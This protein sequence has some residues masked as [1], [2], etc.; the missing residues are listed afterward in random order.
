MSAFAKAE[1]YIARYGEVDDTARLT[2][3][4]EDASNY[5]LSLYIAE[6]GEDY[7]EGV[8]PIFDLNAAAVVCGMVSRVLNVPADM[9]GVSTASQSADIY[10]ASY[11]FANPTGDFYATKSD[12]ERLGLGGTRIGIIEPLT[13]P[14][15]EQLAKDVQAKLDELAESAGV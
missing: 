2:A 7:K 3:Q 4:L 14:I 8:H 11:T 13:A 15:R 12:K 5:I 1:D 10:S 6:Y 9:A